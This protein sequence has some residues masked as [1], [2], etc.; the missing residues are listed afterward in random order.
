[1]RLPAYLRYTEFG[2]RNAAAFKDTGD[3]VCEP[4]TTP[5]FP[6]R[7][8][9]VNVL[10]APGPRVVFDADPGDPEPRVIRTYVA[11]VP[12]PSRFFYFEVTRPEKCPTEPPCGSEHRW[13]IGGMIPSESEDSMGPG[14]RKRCNPATVWSDCQTYG[15]YR[16]RVVKH[17]IGLLMDRKTDR[18]SFYTKDGKKHRHSMSSSVDLI[19]PMVAL[20]GCGAGVSVNFGLDPDRPFLFDAEKYFREEFMGE[21]EGFSFNRSPMPSF[22]LNHMQR[23]GLVVSKR[24]EHIHALRQALDACERD[25]YDLDD[26]DKLLPRDCGAPTETPVWY[27]LLKMALLVRAEDPPNAQ[28]LDLYQQAMQLDLSEDD[29]ARLCVLFALSFSLGAERKAY[30]ASPRVA[31]CLR[32]C[33]DTNAV[34]ARAAK[35]I[36][37]EPVANALREM[38]ADLLVAQ[39]ENNA[40]F[41]N[42]F[43]VTNRGQYSEIAP[44]SSVREINYAYDSLGSSDE[45]DEPSGPE[46]NNCRD[47]DS[48]WSMTDWDNESDLESEEESDAHLGRMMFCAA[49]LAE[50][51]KMSDMREPSGLDHWG[52]DSETEDLDAKEAHADADADVEMGF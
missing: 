12:I 1:M 20:R 27:Y 50:A 5:R 45:S 51:Q 3:S 22:V 52:R 47:S 34:L 36:C 25:F 48:V 17:T 6:C 11:D 18:E 46:D 26:L 35:A 31:A 13:R 49:L 39:N 15:M 30:L 43:V 21:L 33:K 32:E 2:V 24:Y 37:P 38:D 40:A 42:L 19:H 44:D 4:L 7:L 28:L 10:P 41:M 23:V 8:T 29:R 9:Q 16:P 14:A